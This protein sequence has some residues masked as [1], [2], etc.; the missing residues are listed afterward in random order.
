MKY[1][2]LPYAKI[3]IDT[4]CT[5]STPFHDQF[6]TQ[7]V[8]D[9]YK[10]NPLIGLRS[11]AIID[12]DNVR[13]AYPE[14]DCA[15]GYPTSLYTTNLSS[16]TTDA[17]SIRCPFESSSV[18]GLGYCYHHRQVPHDIFDAYSRHASL[19]ADVM[20]TQATL[21]NI[22]K[23]DFVSE[24]I[25]AMIEPCKK[26]A[27]ASQS[28]WFGFMLMSVGLFF[29]WIAALV[30]SGMLREV[31]RSSRLLLSVLFAETL[32]CV[33]SLRECLGSFSRFLES[34]SI[35]VK[36]FMKSLGS[37]CRCFESKSIPVKRYEPPV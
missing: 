7:Y 24:A 21:E 2:C 6:Y 16:F 3:N 10:S 28:L 12:S 34:T 14:T 35:A 18:L 8:C 17:A 15:T 29:L 11:L 4:L 20:D 25:E 36:P 27:S 31:L 5:S 37:L 30:D 1:V 22:A 9:A 23:C 13:Y 32:Q 26:M 19:A 33:G